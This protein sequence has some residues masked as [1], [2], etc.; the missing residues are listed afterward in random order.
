MY[1]AVNEENGHGRE[2]ISMLPAQL[3]RCLCNI[4]LDGASELRLIAGQPLSLRYA[5]GDMYVTSRSSLTR[6]AAGGVRVTRE[7]LC[8]LL[9]KMTGSSLY[10]V[11]DEICSGYITLE[12]GHRA[13][14]AGTA[15]TDNGRV[16]FLRDISA[17]NIRIAKEVIGAADKVMKY[18]T[19]PDGV[20]STLI[21][22]PPGAGKTTMLR[23]IARQLS[24]G[25]YAVS[26]ADERCEI[27]AMRDGMSAFDLGPRTSV[28]DNCPKTAAMLMLLRSMSPDV[29]VT[30]EIGTYEDARAVMSI[31]N[32]GT[33]VI[34]SAHA[35]NIGELERRAETKEAAEMFDLIVVLSRREGPGTVSDIMVRDK[36]G[37]L[38][39]EENVYKEAEV[40]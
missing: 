17:V 37:N 5:D 16:D 15:V 9:E 18:V 24:Y 19:M 8:E 35:R 29:I 39:R 4:D 31:K 12:G 33:A 34:A 14:I 28:T 1:I 11:K 7:Q 36:K 20:R 26:V 10:S 30:D 40:C 23:D 25:G 27:A 22:S 6:L 32:S 38:N 13:G 3:R 21:I 2:L